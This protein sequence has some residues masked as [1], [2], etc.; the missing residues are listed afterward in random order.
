MDGKENKTEKS[1]TYILI[2]L[3]AEMPFSSHCFEFSQFCVSLWFRDK[4]HSMKFCIAYCFECY[5]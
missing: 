1:P 3:L 4:K 2:I 5:S